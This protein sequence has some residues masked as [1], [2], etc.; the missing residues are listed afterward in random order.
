[1][2]VSGGRGDGGVGMM[3]VWTLYLNT[4]SIDFNKLLLGEC[5]C[6]ATE[7]YNT[8]VT[9]IQNVCYIVMRK[10]FIIHL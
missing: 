2:D 1:V 9:Y 5:P 3:G 8:T 6:V 7:T 4:S 10:C